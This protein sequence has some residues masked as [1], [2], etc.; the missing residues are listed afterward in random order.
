MYRIYYE[1][2]RDS[3]R[4]KMAE[5][6]VQTTMAGTG[7]FEILHSSAHFMLFIHLHSRVLLSVMDERMRLLFDQRMFRQWR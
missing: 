1:F 4:L 6:Q 5:N 7:Q 2:G 3:K